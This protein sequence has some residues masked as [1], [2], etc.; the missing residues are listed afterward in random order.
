MP[1]RR[2]WTDTIWVFPTSPNG[3]P[4]VGVAVGL[5][6]GGDVLPIVDCHGLFVRNDVK[7]PWFEFSG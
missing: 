4:P 6:F 3:L 7:E 1:S 2:S 5:S